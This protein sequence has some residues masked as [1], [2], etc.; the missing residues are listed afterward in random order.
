MR[1]WGEVMA[2]AAQQDDGNNRKTRRTEMRLLALWAI[3]VSAFFL[4]Q[5]ILYKGIAGRLAEWQF[6]RFDTYFPT[7]TLL[8]LVALFTLPFLALLAL[9]RRL[10]TSKT[11]MSS[12]SKAIAAGGSFLRI[13]YG[14]TFMAF[15][16]SIVTMLLM[17]R[18]PS[19]GGSVQQ[20]KLTA[21]YDATP[22][23]GP[24]N[25]I[26]A[27][28]YRHVAKLEENLGPIK[29]D[30][31]FAPIVASGS[32][33]T[34]IDYFVEVT[35]SKDNPGAFMSVGAGILRRNSLPGELVS[36]YRKSGYAVARPHYVLHKSVEAMQW[37]FVIVAVQYAVTGLILLIVA[38]L[39]RRH[40]NRLKDNLSEISRDA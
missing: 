4:W 31:Y 19:E 28:D 36:L 8:A 10:S 30:T 6:A 39:Y 14:L 38:L 34:Q 24:T 12:R 35:P 17:L 11:E 16:A 25:L 2:A 1:V 3:I 23:E 27:I 22:N 37:P 32:K 5:T 7:L 33:P 18:L 29:R 9:K 26:G 40:R 15:L 20:I 21:R 13:L